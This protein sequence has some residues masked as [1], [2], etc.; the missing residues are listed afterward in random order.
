MASFDTLASKK[1]SLEALRKKINEEFKEQIAN[2][3][4]DFFK[5]NPTVYAFAWAQYTPYFN[6][7]D[8][9]TFRVNDITA[10][11]DTEATR[12]AI[13]EKD[14]SLFW[15]E[16]EDAVD[17]S[18]YDYSGGYSASTR[19]PRVLTDAE[20]NTDE[21]IRQLNQ[22][23]DEFLYAFGD[24]VSVTVTRDGVDVEEYDHD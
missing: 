19:K 9:C 7:G 21:F 17:T 4:T 24:H 20:K 6:D 2:V 15:G 3:F 10:Y 8:T 16:G 12:E 14:S 1:Q 23:E 22:F 18:E 5:E 13:E 11:Y